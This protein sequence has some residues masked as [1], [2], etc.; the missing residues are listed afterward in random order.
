MTDV[1][2]A[3]QSQ[4]DVAERNFFGYPLSQVAKMRQSFDA[5]RV[6]GVLRCSPAQS[7]VNREIVP[8]QQPPR[9]VRKAH[10][11][12]EVADA[13]REILEVVSILVSEPDTPHT[14]PPISRQGKK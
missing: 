12:D 2:E 1:W 4:L 14:P 8:V 10:V 9:V 11:F 7:S 6:D 5:K 13:W 3:L